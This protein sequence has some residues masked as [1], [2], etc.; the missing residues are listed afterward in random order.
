MVR[1]VFNMYRFNQLIV[2]FCIYHMQTRMSALPLQTCV[3]HGTEL[4]LCAWTGRVMTRHHLDT[5]VDVVMVTLRVILACVSVSVHVKPSFTAKAKAKRNSYL[6]S[7]QIIICHV[8]W[9]WLYGPRKL[10]SRHSLTINKKKYWYIWIFVTKMESNKIFYKSTEDD[11][12][13]FKV[14]SNQ[15]F[16]N[17]I[18]VSFMVTAIIE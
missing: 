7:K 10:H 6:R 18:Y 5:R 15:I 14:A 4:I 8:R 1:F 11:L 16:Q 3:P 2:W 17:S 13:L 12:I 9:K